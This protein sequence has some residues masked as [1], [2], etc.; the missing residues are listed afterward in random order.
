MVRDV[1]GIEYV[2]GQKC[3]PGITT[4]YY[5]AVGGRQVTQARG[6]CVVEYKFGGKLTF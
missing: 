6:P 3:E 2:V 5:G 4:D 1:S